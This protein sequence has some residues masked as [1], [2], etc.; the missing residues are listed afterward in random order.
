MTFNSVRIACNQTSSRE[1]VVGEDEELVA[2]C[3]VVLRLAEHEDDFVG[4]A[5][6]EF[7]VGHHR[8]TGIS[9]FR[10]SV[11]QPLQGQSGRGC[12]RPE[13]PLLSVTSDYSTCTWFWSTP[14]R[15]P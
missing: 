5:G 15:S 6:G 12:C 9:E 1:L 8:T 2:R 4:P 14:H 3:A 13:C 11:G 7:Q 10:D